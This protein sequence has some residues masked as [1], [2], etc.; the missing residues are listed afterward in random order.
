[1]PDMKMSDA[2]LRFLIAREGNVSSMYN[3]NAGHCTI[4]VGHLVH[5]GPMEFDTKAHRRPFEGQADPHTG[6]TPRQAADWDAERP[7]FSRL[8]QDQVVELLHTDIQR[9]EAAVNKA[10]TVE[11]S[12][13]QFD[14]LV[15]FCFNVGVKAFTNST[16]TKLV[17]QKR[18]DD[19]SLEF[20]KW[21][22]SGHKINHG[23]VNRRE[24][25]TSLFTKGDYRTHEHAATKNLT[26]PKH[27]HPKKIHHFRHKHHKA[28]ETPHQPI[29]IQRLG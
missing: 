13:S 29:V 7:F 19:A 1:M 8:S 26:R 22:K 28:D 25:E 3:D 16:L 15:S 21:I 5:L 2:G 18:F 9:Y 12:Q 23:L 27:G 6:M 11:L 20:G 14:A 10:V 24:H 17:N 4:G